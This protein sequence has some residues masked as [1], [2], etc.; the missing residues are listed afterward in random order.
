[1]IIMTTGYLSPLLRKAW[2]RDLSVEI[3]ALQL[4]ADLCGDCSDSDKANQ[5]ANSTSTEVD[6]G[7]ITGANVD[8]HH[9]REE[10]NMCNAILF[11]YGTEQLQI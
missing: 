6:K 8:L 4:F 10:K 7:L 1:M 9:E 5:K 3:R 11:V 2:R